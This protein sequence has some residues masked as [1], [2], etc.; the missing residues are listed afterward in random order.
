[1]RRI[2][3]CLIQ[4]F[5][6]NLIWKAVDTFITV[7]LICPVRVFNLFLHVL[8]YVV[9]LLI[10]RRSIKTCFLKWHRN[11]ETE[12]DG[13]FNLK[14]AYWV[15]FS[16]M[17]I[18]KSDLP[19]SVFRL[20]LWRFTPLGYLC[21]AGVRAQTFSRPGVGISFQYVRLVLS[22]TWPLSLSLFQ[23]RQQVVWEQEGAINI[24]PPSS[25]L[26]V[27]RY[28]LI[29]HVSLLPALPF[30][31][32]PPSFIII[33]LLSPSL[34]LCCTRLPKFSRWVGGGATESRRL[35]PHIPCSLL[36]IWAVISFV[37]MLAYKVGV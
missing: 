17:K 32:L 4:C 22:Q 37:L 18:I 21:R 19:P 29:R 5:R 11:V 2:I 15:C 20:L 6:L 8:F 13:M 27:F 12:W 34:F 31:H 36:I 33:I 35:T 1:M 26:P 23:P 3:N 9:F 14:N 16:I 30:L 24:L 10:W 28:L 7:I 25:F